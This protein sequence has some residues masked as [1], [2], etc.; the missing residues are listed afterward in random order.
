MSAEGAA[1]TPSDCLKCRAFGAH[2]STYLP[3]PASRPGLRTG[4]PS[5]LILISEREF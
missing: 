1:L 5:G 4:G 3:I 2:F